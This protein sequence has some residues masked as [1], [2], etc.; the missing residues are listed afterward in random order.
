MSP[1]AFEVLCAALRTPLGDASR[2]LRLVILEV[3]NILLQTLAASRWAPSPDDSKVPI[4]APD[5]TR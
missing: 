2:W 3:C 4:V 1:L 5:A